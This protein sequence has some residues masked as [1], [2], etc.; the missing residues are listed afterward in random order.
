VIEM[1]ARPY[2]A[3]VVGVASYPCLRYKSTR[4]ESEEPPL[5]DAVQRFGFT[6]TVAT[7]LAPASWL[8]WGRRMSV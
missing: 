3:H 2:A 7:E 1:G 5:P 6:L 8:R 4:R